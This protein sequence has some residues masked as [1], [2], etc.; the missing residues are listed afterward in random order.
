MGEQDPHQVRDWS[1]LSALPE[2][3]FSRIDLAASNWPLWKP[4]CSHCLP[5]L[6]PPR[7][8]GCNYHLQAGS[9]LIPQL[10]RDSHFPK[11]LGWFLTSLRLQPLHS[12]RL[13]NRWTSPVPSCSP[14]SV[15]PASSN[16]SITFTLRVEILWA[17]SGQP[18]LYTAFCVFSWR[19][20]SSPKLH[21]FLPS[22]CCISLAI[23]LFLVIFSSSFGHSV[24]SDSLWPHGLQHARS[25]C[26]S[27]IPRV[28][29]N[30]CLSSRWCHPTFSSCGV[31]FSSCPQSFPESGSF[32]VTQ[33][34]TSGGHSIGVS[35]STSVLPVNT[36]DWFPLGWTG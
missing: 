22:D 19:T 1:M 32:P 9:S 6:N 26:P 34:F 11:S 14:S 24:M 8:P 7:L 21:P 13:Q 28:Y 36:Q 3:T 18:V 23:T 16:S 17:D 29:S 2:A 4:W 10:P 35:A 5:A 31:P 25:P 12:C 27:P 20:V 30:S 15:S 33:L